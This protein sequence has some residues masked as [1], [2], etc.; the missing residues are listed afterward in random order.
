MT[1]I[2]IIG[3]T[4]LENPQI[5]KDSEEI[6]IK[7][8]YGDPSSTLF[9]G[10]IEGVEVVLL[11]RHNRDHSIPPTEVNKRAN[12]YAIKELGCTYIIATTACIAISTDCDAWKEDEA[13]VTRE[14]V[15]AIFSQNVDRVIDLILKTLPMVK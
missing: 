11:S 8:P 5:L 3:G 6:S 10:N 7:T 4:G 12:I 2:A 9:T 13:A 14:E 15:L 1:K